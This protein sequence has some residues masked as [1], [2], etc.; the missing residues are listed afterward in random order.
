MNFTLFVAII[1]IITLELTVCFSTSGGS[2]GFQR[3][4][5]SKGF[6]KKNDNKESRK[7]KEQQQ[8]TEKVRNFDLGRG[9][10]VNLYVPDDALNQ[11]LNNKG[12]SSRKKGNNN[13]KELLSENSLKR[14]YGTGDVVWPSSFALARLLAHCPSFV[15]D[16]KVLELGCGLGLVSATIYQHGNAE[17]ITITDVDN[18]VLEKAYASCKDL[19]PTTTTSEQVTTSISYA[20]M[21]WT[22]ESTWPDKDDYEF[23]LLVASDVL[24]DENSIQPLIKVLKHYLLLPSNN[25][26]KEY[27][28]KNEEEQTISKRAMIVDPINRSNRDVFCIAAKNIGI[29]AECIPFPGMEDDFV[30]INITPI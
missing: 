26:N 27:N 12:L 25:N 8:Q 3:N 16:K 2:K 13:N 17:H 18:S 10:K 9:K 23:D 30:L 15:T 28:Q 19:C 1:L 5:N 22:D 21:N 14:Y 4:N 24:Y 29:D 20:T 7:L 6:Q 11:E